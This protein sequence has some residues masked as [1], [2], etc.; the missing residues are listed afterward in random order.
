MKGIT[1][2]H[3]FLMLKVLILKCI[4][5]THENFITYFDISSFFNILGNL[6]GSGLFLLTFESPENNYSLGIVFDFFF[7]LFWFLT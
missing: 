4:V 7:V 2:W 1:T 5:I 3:S 6:N